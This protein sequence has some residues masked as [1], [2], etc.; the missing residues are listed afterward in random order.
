MN[1]PEQPKESWGCLQWGV[2]AM[3]LVLAV[4]YLLPYRHVISHMSD[5]TKAANN[6]RQIIVALKIWASDN[7]GVFPDAGAPPPTSSNQVFRKL[8][9]DGIVKD[10][11]I[12]GSTNSPFLPDNEL[13]DAPDYHRAVEPGEN[14][15]AIVARLKIDNAG[16]QP[17]IFENT[18]SSQWPPRWLV[19]QTQPV[20]GRTW[21]RGRIIVGRLDNSVNTEQLVERNGVLTLPSSFLNPIGNELL[22]PLRILDIEEKK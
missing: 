20:R 11:R 6:C 21:K 18:T 19:N 7:N 12:F 8:I 16:T 5:Q 3:V 13:G 10:E 17:Q 15:W 9:R 14:H 22:P 1:E 4:I 2:V